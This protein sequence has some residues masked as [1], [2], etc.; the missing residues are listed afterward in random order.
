MFWLNDGHE[1]PGQAISNHWDAFI[2]KMLYEIQ[3]VCHINQWSLHQSINQ[4]SVDIFLHLKCCEHEKGSERRALTVG[5]DQHA[6]PAH[7]QVKQ[8]W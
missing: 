6:T 7:H 2:V 3:C 5:C 1:G 4:L 8:R